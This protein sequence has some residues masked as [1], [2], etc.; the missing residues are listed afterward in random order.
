MMIKKVKMY[1]LFSEISKNNFVEAV[2]ICDNGESFENATMQTGV[3]PMGAFLSK[4]I[5][6]L[7]IL[8]KQNFSRLKYSEMELEA[9]EIKEF[10]S[11]KDSAYS[12]LIYDDVVACA[13]FDL[14]LR[15]RQYMYTKRNKEE[16][17]KILQR[18]LNYIRLC[19][20]ENG[21]NYSSIQKLYLLLNQTQDI[22]PAHSTYVTNTL[23]RRNLLSES[24]I[25]NFLLDITYKN[26]SFSPSLKKHKQKMF[27][28]LKASPLYNV[29][30]T[31]W[32]ELKTP[33]EV[34][35][36]TDIIDLILASVYCIFQQGYFLKEC[37][38]CKSLFIIRDRRKKYCPNLDIDNKSCYGTSRLEKQLAREKS[39]SAKIE[40]SLRTMFAEKAKKYGKE[41]K[42]YIEYIKF[43]DE[44]KNRRDKIK[45][46][47]AT[48][49]EYV[50]WMK[51]HYSKK[52]KDK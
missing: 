21:E 38:Y 49:D 12:N 52:Y 35:D 1:F 25:E 40:K 23:D 22:M 20:N 27:N 47:N 8:E 42:A 44:C 30:K 11:K 6:I 48:E 9:E 39:K 18:Y 33:L 31:K 37:P 17:T 5:K 51:G 36:I 43:L 24:E 34:F 26:S 28:Q 10:F 13:V 3:Y 41:S 29:K 15:S 32:G 46:G 50:K 7:D 16:F 45:I 14:L 4:A 2:Y 19:E